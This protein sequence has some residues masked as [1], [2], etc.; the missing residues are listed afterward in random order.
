MININDA[1]YNQLKL[2]NSQI[3]AIYFDLD[4]TL[5]PS[6][7]LYY[8]SYKHLK[9]KMPI[10]SKARELIK[11]ELGNTHVCSKNRTLY[12]KKYLELCNNNNTKEILKLTS[13][14]EL[15]FMKKL[16]NHHSLF[17]TKIAL[18]K[19][20]KKYYLGLVTN[21]NTRTQLLKLS[22]LDPTGNLFDFVLTSEEIGAEKPSKKM[23]TQAIRKSNFPE[24]KILFVGDSISNDL[25]SFS[26]NGCHVIGTRQFRDESQTKNNYYW[27]NKI[28]EL[29][30]LLL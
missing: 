22:I 9:L 15:F 13:N 17:N 18:K 3:K 6:E 16:K 20:K 8:L 21:E 12:F 30:N 4:D 2:K 23:I 19:L 1:K 28:D 25:N 11:K 7:E 29:L 27:I 24:N 5:I 26:K 14:Y 10:F